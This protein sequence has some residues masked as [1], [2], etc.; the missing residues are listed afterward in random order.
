MDS[1]ALWTARQSWKGNTDLV[2]LLLNP[3]DSRW[4][5]C[6]N[7]LPC[8]PVPF[9]CALLCFL[10]EQC[11]FWFGHRIARGGKGN[12]CYC[13]LN[14]YRVPSQTTGVNLQSGSWLL[15]EGVLR[16]TFLPSWSPW[17]FHL[18]SLWASFCRTSF[19]VWC[20]HNVGVLFW[21]S[22][23]RRSEHQLQ[24]FCVWCHADWGQT[25]HF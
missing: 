16:L 1:L 5:H 6:S 10:I 8:G 12:V 23:K 20:Y 3:Q 19:Q 15:K 4:K 14:I 22:F 21:I 7:M 2:I 11:F 18:T 24:Y 9:C 13:L 25:T 17:F